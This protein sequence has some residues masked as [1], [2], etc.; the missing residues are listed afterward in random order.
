MSSE[1]GL[2]RDA[3]GRLVKG[4]PPGPGRPPGS[5]SIKERVRQY[6]DDHPESMEE[7]IKHFVDENRGLAWQ[8]LEGR[9]PQDLTSGGEKINPTPL[10]ANISVPNNNGDSEDS[11]ATEENTSGTGGN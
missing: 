5:F 1:L 7:F 4:T 8:M 9:P 10:L 3:K 11:Q 6:L 2:K